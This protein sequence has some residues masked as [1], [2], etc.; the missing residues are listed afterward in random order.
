MNIIN[1]NWIMNSPLE[2]FNI[3]Y[4]YIIS[5]KLIDISISNYVIMLIIA[6]N[7]LMYLFYIGINK[8]G[9]II[10]SKI[11]YLLITLYRNAYNFIIDII[12]I[13]GNKY[14]P[15]IINIFIFILINNIIGLIP[16]SITTTS[17]IIV[18]FILSNSIII[19][20]T[21]IGILEHSYK[22]INLFI[23]KGISIYILP[24]ITI[25]EII[26]YISRIISLSLRLT[27]NM[28]AGHTIIYIISS[29]GLLLSLFNKIVLI[30]PILIL[31]L[32]LEIGVSII[33]AFVFSIL[34]ATYI[35][36]ALEL[37]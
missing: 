30:I 1:N 31:I 8:E 37:H 6:G 16:Y 7:I 33:Q 28:I 35:K 32:I 13:R 22:F 21:I 17:Q 11:T 24:L 2:Q 14:Y 19:G 26:S 25:I 29:F 34:T 20:V 15:I 18:T 9:K 4:Y 23:P 3:N 10:T 5:N 36:N 27:A 12:T